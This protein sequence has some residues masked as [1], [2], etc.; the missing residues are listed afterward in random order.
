[1][2]H[3]NGYA[4]WARISQRIRVW[5]PCIGSVINLLSNDIRREDCRQNKG[6]SDWRG[7]SF[8][9]TG[10]PIGLASL[11]IWYIYSMSFKLWTWLW[12][13]FLWW[14]H[15][16]SIDLCD[17]CAQ[18]HRVCFT[19]TGVHPLDS[20]HCPFGIYT[21]CPLNCEHGCDVLF[22]GGITSIL[23]IYVIYVHRL[24]GFAS[25]PLG[26]SMIAPVPVR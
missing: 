9:V 20:P 15:E 22:C 26:Q 25:R 19:A 11:P 2:E 4:E 8:N 1:M 7:Q 10:T 14:Y 6:L 17:I 3:P 13:A 21:V 18:T 24:I 12:C 16:Y 23:L 5:G